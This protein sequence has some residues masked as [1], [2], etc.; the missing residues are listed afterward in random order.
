[1]RV[2]RLSSLEFSLPLL[3]ITLLVVM[4]GV[5]SLL[6]YHEVRAASLQSGEARLER[7]SGELAEVM[8]RS[9]GNASRG[10]GRPARAPRLDHGLGPGGF[11]PGREFSQ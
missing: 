10:H 5:G 11:I 4:I 8:A 9:V 1:M 2:N 6:A 3:I 7:V